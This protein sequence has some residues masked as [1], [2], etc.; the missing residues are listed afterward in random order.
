MHT[1][2]CTN[3]GAV[4]SSDSEMKVCPACQTP[5]T[6][7]SNVTASVAGGNAATGAD[8]IAIDSPNQAADKPVAVPVV[9]APQTPPPAPDV[10]AAP[11]TAEKVVGGLASMLDSVDAVAALIEKS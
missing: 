8:V 4:S 7:T 3:C 11:S 10:S 9:S 2:S 1:L 6:S 5:A